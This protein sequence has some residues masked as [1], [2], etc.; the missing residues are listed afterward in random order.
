MSYATPPAAVSPARVRLEV[1]GGVVILAPLAAFG[2]PFIDHALNPGATTPGV[3]S[4]FGVGLSV[5]ALTA[6]LLLAGLRDVLPRT[7]V[8]LVAMIGYS[9]VLVLIKF[10]LGP[11][12]LYVTSEQKG[13]VVLNTDH[14]G[15]AFIAFPAL[16][17]VTA[18][19]YGLAFFLLYLYFNSDLRRRLG[20]NVRLE[21]GFMSLLLTMFIVAVVGS[22]TGL[23]LFGFLEYLS[24]FF[25]LLALA[26]L[27]ALALVSALALCSVAF[28]EATEQAVML[29][30]VTLLSAFAW[31]GLAFI[32]AYHIVWLIFI[33][34][35][36]SLWPLKTMNLK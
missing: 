6:V 26:A 4:Y 15:L 5:L 22:I 11:L 31:V 7:G 12:A 20:I 3:L 9:A 21:R 8:F 16:A 28:H 24:S 10:G 34:T 14:N 27:L 30:N 23:G 25:S 33:L 32:A 18:I 13:F 17:A 36:V 1:V 29:R 19:L 2:F 35:L